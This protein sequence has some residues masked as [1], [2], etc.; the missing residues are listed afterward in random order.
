MDTCFNSVAIISNAA[1]IVIVYMSLHTVQA[2]LKYEFPGI[3]LL[4]QTELYFQYWKNKLLKIWN[5][6]WIFHKC[7]QVILGWIFW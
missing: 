4:G 2:S 3:E 6:K 1:I 5:K 7:I